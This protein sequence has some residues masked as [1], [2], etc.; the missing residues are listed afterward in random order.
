VLPAYFE[1][2]TK[3]AVALRF[4]QNGSFIG[5]TRI[6]RRT[7]TLQPALLTLSPTH[8]LALMRD[9]GQDGKIRAS[10][11]LDSGASWQDAN[12]LPLP[13]PDAGIA[14]LSVG[15][16]H[17]LAYNPSNEN[18][19]ALTLANSNT[20]ADWTTVIELERGQQGHEYSYPAMA[21]AD[22]SLWVSYTDRRK[23]IAWRR[24]DW[25]PGTS[26]P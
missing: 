10:Q 1:F 23:S 11:T 4:D 6:S 13:N 26:A 15:N 8:W 2:G 3:T 18:R 25:K 9:H 7:F 20:G 19:N 16:M 22:N 17:L 24:F 12:D 5:M 21:W 14:T